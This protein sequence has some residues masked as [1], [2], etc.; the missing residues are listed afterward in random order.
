MPHF[1]IAALR[2][3]GGWDPYNVTE[4]ADLGIRL[5]RRGL[6]T[7]TLNSTTWEEAPPDFGNWWRQ[8][9]R[10]LK[11]WMQTWIVHMRRP[12][13]LWRDLGAFRFIG[14]HVFMGGMLLSVI[15]YPLFWS[16]LAID[17]MFGQLYQ[18]PES[19]FGTWFWMICGAN[20]VM[21]FTASI[22]VGVL[23][24][25]RR[26]NRWLAPWT[27]LMPVYWL[28]IS[29]AGYRAMWQL[30]RKPFLWEKTKHGGHPPR[31]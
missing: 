10:W 6:R 24:A 7:A 2:A 19:E 9:T 27:L 4:D 15:A 23:A 20:L 11:G 22:L 8:R 31:R 25:I 18:S 26:G 16:M 13:T 29:M 17:L 5:A 30:F 14:L 12:R 1:P 21:G 28:A 3:V